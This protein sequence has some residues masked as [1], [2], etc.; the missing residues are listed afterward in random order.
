MEPR[1]FLSTDRKLV[2]GKRP[3]AYNPTD[4]HHSQDTPKNVTATNGLP[5][6]GTGHSYTFSFGNYHGPAIPRPGLAKFLFDCEY[7]LF[8]Q[9]PA[10]GRGVWT[11][12]PRGKYVCKGDLDGAV[13]LKMIGNHFGWNLAIH[14]IAFLIKMMHEIE[15]VKDGS[16]FFDFVVNYTNE[17]DMDTFETV[18]YGKWESTGAITAVTSS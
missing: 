6:A 2:R 10:S 11:P 16:R 15:G 14:D 5:N 1:L 18:A 4:L 7:G 3:T 12:Y 17:S 13:S 9:T 8:D